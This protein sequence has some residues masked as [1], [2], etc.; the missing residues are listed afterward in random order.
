MGSRLRGGL[1]ALLVVGALFAV[2]APALGDVLGE[3]AL[4]V[5]LSDDRVRPG[6]NTQLQLTVS[7]AGEIESG[8]AVGNVNAEQRVMTARGVSVD[9][10]ADGT[11]IEVQTGTVTLGAVPDSATAQVPVGISV[12]E[13]ATPGTYEM[14]V[15][16]EY[17]HTAHIVEGQNTA[18]TQYEET[19]ERTFTV[20]VRVERAAAFEVVDVTSTAAVGETGTLSV[21]VRNDG[22]AA[23]REATLSTESSDAG[24]AF[25]DAPSVAAT[26]G[27][28]E[29]NETRTVEHTARVAPTAT[30]RTFSLQHAVT[31][32]DED[33]V[34]REERLTSSVTAGP[35]QTFRA[36]GADADVGVGERGNVTLRVTN[37]GERNLTDATL[38]VQSPNAALTFGGSPTARLHVGDW[39]AGETVAVTLGVRVAPGAERRSYALEVTPGYTTPGGE[40]ARAEPLSVGI[41]PRAEQTFAVENVSTTAGIGE[42]GTV[43]IAV[44]NTGER[45]LTDAT[46]AVQSPNAA[47]TFGGSPT[48][49]LHVGDWAA[50][51]VARVTVEASVAPGAERRSYALEVTPGYTTPGGERGSA[52]PLSAGVA[53]GA[54]QTFAVENA[55]L[56][57]QVGAEGTL[58]GEVANRGPGAVE[59]AVLVLQPAGPN[60]D[61]VESEVAIGSLAPGERAPFAF[62]L[63]AG[64]G[65]AAGPRQFALRL[66]YENAAGDSRRSDPLYA[67]G[68]VDER[69][70]TFQVDPVEATFEAGASG[71]LVLRVTNTDDQVLSDVSAKLFVDDPLSSSDDEAFVA[72]LDPGESANV[73]FGLDV[74]GGAIPKAYPVSVDFQ[75]EE[76]DGDTKLSDTYR[77]PVTVTESSDGG[78]LAALPTGG[79]AVAA[80]LLVLAVLAVAYVRRRR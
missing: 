49:R 7:N 10:S 5:T 6:E 67:R 43:T 74:G 24:F 68:T 17:T 73:T 14:E 12:A 47:L 2:P 51:E 53:P 70:A 36:A 75:Y 55:T 15:D 56:S 28:V 77:A 78:S 8:S 62:D 41:T 63:E 54:E 39:A 79:L 64:T 48:A 59:N 32:E 71:R 25:G 19:V 35:E 4:S 50:G 13:S 34:L 40:S 69:R 3:P 9:A 44:R 65:A 1:L 16:V 72:G 80:V 38:A 66:D 57:L 29:P 42:T 27:T 22:T 37:T 45:N 23:A 11:P 52:E 60:V 20:E 33:G 46:L 76:P 18:G 26:L 30:A 21:T 58:I 61:V 31:Y